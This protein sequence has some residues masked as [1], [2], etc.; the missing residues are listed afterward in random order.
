MDL[1]ALGW[2]G[3]AWRGLCRDGAA[4]NGIPFVIAL[5]VFE[6]SRGTAVCGCR[7]VPRNEALQTTRSREMADDQQTVLV[8]RNW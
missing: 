5:F 4:W 1:G 2:I 6:S 7:L 3:V 8:Y